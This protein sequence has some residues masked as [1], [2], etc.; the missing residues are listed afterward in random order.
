MRRQFIVCLVWF[1]T[2][3]SF[4]A[5]ELLPENHDTLEIGPRLLFNGN[6]FHLN[7]AVENSMSRKFLF[8]G[9][10][11]DEIKESSM[12]NHES[13]NRMGGGFRT[14]LQYF[15]DK[16]VL[17]KY[18]DLSW[19]V[20]VSNEAHFSS[21]YTAG[22]FS[23]VFFGNEF[24][25]GTEMS[26]TNSVGSYLQ[27]YSAG[28]GFHNKKTKSFLS[29]N[30]LLPRNYLNFGINEGYYLTSEDASSIDLT[31]N[32]EVEYSNSP[33]YFQ[34]LGIGI[35]FDY[36]M[37]F[38]EGDTNDFHGFFRISGRN[39]GVVRLHDIQRYQVNTEMNFDGFALDEINRFFEE[40]SDISEGLKDSLNLESSNGS[41]WMLVPGFLQAGRIVEANRLSKF[42]SFFGIRLY[43]NILYR[44][45]VY[46]G[47]D[48]K[49][50]ENLS[51]GTQGTFGGYG[52]FRIGAYANYRTKIGS[53]GLGTEDILGVASS[54]QYGQSVVLRLL[55][56]L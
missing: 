46:A 33:A 18:P 4:Y 42:Q 54:K 3:F 20:N 47:V 45:L 53:V 28:G 21:E 31:L 55:W 24:S 10:I 23:L 11:T 35:S 30:L 17:D 14:T 36:N 15:S 25:S 13:F 37:P 7:Y 51:F 27:Y 1:S 48:F 12:E 56:K 6:G 26:L 52:R 34:G 8:G 9:E 22:L 49:A 16:P 29:L 5:Q 40:D 2:V 44:P 32:A 39:L 38:G 41:R 43:T 50:N 19:M